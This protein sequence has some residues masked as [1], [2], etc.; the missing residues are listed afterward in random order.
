MCFHQLTVARLVISGQMAQFHPSA[1]S[2]AKYTALWRPG[3]VVGPEI[4]TGII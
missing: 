1:L 2:V 4:T 3:E